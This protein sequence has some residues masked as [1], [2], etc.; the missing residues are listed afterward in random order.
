M[1]SPQVAGRRL[2]VALERLLGLADLPGQPDDG[3]VGLELR[4]GLLQQ[5]AGASRPTWCTRLTAM[6]YDGRNDERS[7]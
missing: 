6:L 7:G 1:K 4:E 5:L 2:G 3:P